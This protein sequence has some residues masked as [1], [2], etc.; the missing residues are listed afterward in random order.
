MITLSGIIRENMTFGSGD[1]V[2]L[3]GNV[4]IAEGY[5]VTLG[6]G[7]ALLGNSKTI[8]V[9]GNLVISGTSENLLEV[10]KVDITGS[11]SMNFVHYS[12]KYLLNQADWSITNSVIEILTF[13]IPYVF[14][15]SA[16]RTPTITNTSNAGIYE[17]K[18]HTLI[19]TGLQLQKAFPRNSTYIITGYRVVA[20]A[21][22][23]KVCM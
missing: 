16:T 10:E 13:N 9:F 15:S 1:T 8:E 12:G 18:T 6:A 23:L 11:V 4:Q 20:P 3:S 7:S 2:S 22:T 19:A 17:T 5:T 14:T 21:P